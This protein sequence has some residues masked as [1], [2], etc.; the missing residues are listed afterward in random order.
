MRANAKG[1]GK[2]AWLP[3][4]LFLPNP[5]DGASEALKSRGIG[6]AQAVPE[7]LIPGLTRLGTKAEAAAASLEPAPRAGNNFAGLNMSCIQPPPSLPYKLLHWQNYEQQSSPQNQ[8][9][10]QYREAGFTHSTR[11]YLS[12]QEDSQLVTV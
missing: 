10:Q 7:M 9:R 12:L 6:S 3:C 2:A 5:S 1:E 11:F 8:G 4:R